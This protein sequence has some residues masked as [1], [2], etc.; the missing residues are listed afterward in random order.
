MFE[1]DV[2]FARP[3]RGVTL[4]MHRYRRE[5]ANARAPMA[6]F[7]HG[8]AWEHG[9]PYAH[10]RRACL[11]AAH[12]WVTATTTYRRLPQARWPDPLDDVEEALEHLVTRAD[13]IGGDPERLAVVGDS[14][15]AQLAMLVC[16]RVPGVRAVV[17]WCPVTD[18]R[19]TPA[20]EAAITRLTHDDAARTDASPVEHAGDG[21]PPTLSFAGALDEVVPL[22]TIADYHQR[23]AAAG[24]ANELVV[25]EN[26]GHAFDFDPVAWTET[27]TTAREFLETHVRNAP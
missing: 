21:M 19:S 20:L 8:G 12:G 13:D 6:L 18:L 25:Y 23:L 27:F 17:T 2:V 11:L 10:I 1:P 16:L 5:D 14:S 15:G 3:R 7:V 26:A 22:A 4:I 24:V 9:H